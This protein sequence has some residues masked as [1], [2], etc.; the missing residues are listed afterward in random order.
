MGAKTMLGSFVK[1]RRG[2]LGLT[3]QQLADKAG[4]TTGAIYMIERGERRRL[5]PET[6]S[7][8]SRSLEVTPDV[9]LSLISSPAPRQ[10][11]PA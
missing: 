10:E 7:A 11:V 3:V 1:Q 6:I 5:Q 2:E 4:M 9:L 8:L